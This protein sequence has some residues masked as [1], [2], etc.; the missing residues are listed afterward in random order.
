MTGV[1]DEATLELLNNPRNRL[2]GGA[3]QGF[4]LFGM[5]LNRNNRNRNRNRNG[6]D[7]GG[8]ANAEKGTGAGMRLRYS[9]LR[10]CLADNTPAAVIGG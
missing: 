4:L 2:H 9:Q 1:R 3:N 6:G 8:G 5:G 7:S 10:T